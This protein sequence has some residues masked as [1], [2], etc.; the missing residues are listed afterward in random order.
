[1]LLSIRVKA[2]VR[3]VGAVVL[4]AFAAV[5]SVAEAQP[6]RDGTL[7]RWLASAERAAERGHMERAR[8]LWRRAA[9]RAPADAR[10]P[11]RFVEKALPQDAASVAAPTSSVRA[12]ALEAQRWLMAHLDVADSPEARRALAWVTAV[13][14][15]H[16]AAIETAAGIVRPHDA[17]TAELL[18]RLATLAVL[19][20]NLPAAERALAAAMHALPQDAA[21]LTELGI[22]E[23]ARGRPDRAVEHFA[24]VLGQR[25]DDLRARRD[26][27]GAL[28]AAGRAAEGV[29]L[30]S[31]A[32][33][34]HPSEPEVQ[35][36]LARA[37]LETGNAAVA[38]RAARAAAAVLPARDARA[39]ATLGEALAARGRLVEAEAAFTEALRRDPEDLRARTG[40]E[41]LRRRRPPS[42]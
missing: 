41:S 29:E 36:E 17:S 9:R 7:E 26:L 35:L 34:A 22:V 1:M 15:D 24:R 28:V 4:G 14:G 23:L 39:H 2:R 13:L 31:Q 6:R 30:L 8:A 38:E 27:A 12:R 5:S 21:I 20:D 19:R 16:T 42:P 32:A 3:V 37:A 11:V 40:L 10:A 18:R 25:P 33:Q